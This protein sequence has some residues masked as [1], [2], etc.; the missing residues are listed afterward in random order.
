MRIFQQDS[1]MGDVT[2]CSLVDKSQH[3]EGTHLHLPVG[4]CPEEVGSKLL[5]YG[6]I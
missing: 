1:H 6:P 5:R 4:F 3:L 2:P